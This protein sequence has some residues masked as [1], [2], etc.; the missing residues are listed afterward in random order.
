VQL[1]SENDKSRRRRLWSSPQVRQDLSPHVP[2]RS[3]ARRA[4]VRAQ[5]EWQCSM[6]VVPAA[7]TSTAADRAPAA[8]GVDHGKGVR[9]AV[10]EFRAFPNTQRFHLVESPGGGPRV[11]MA[12]LHQRLQ[13]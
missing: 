12:F 7:G 6:G 2:E 9:A 5:L 3:Q 13:R 10:Y 4:A 11:R 1:A 8:R